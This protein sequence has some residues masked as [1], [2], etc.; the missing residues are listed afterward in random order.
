MS[1]MCR[2]LSVLH[3]GQNTKPRWSEHD[4]S[5]VKTRRSG[6]SYACRLSQKWASKAV[7][8]HDQACNAASGWLAQVPG[9]DGQERIGRAA[10]NVVQT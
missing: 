5:G 6:S 10:S 1:E 9:I 8:C 4:G 2:I 7:V 3:R